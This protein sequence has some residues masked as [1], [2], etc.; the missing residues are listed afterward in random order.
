[1]KKFMALISIG[2]MLALSGCVVDGIT[3]NKAKWAAETAIGDKLGDNVTLSLIGNWGPC[4]ES[5][6][7]TY[8]WKFTNETGD[9]IVR[10]FEGQDGSIWSTEIDDPGYMYMLNKT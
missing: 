1:M 8:V 7:Y 4:C 5:T 2:L 3:N 6:P 9:H 10:V